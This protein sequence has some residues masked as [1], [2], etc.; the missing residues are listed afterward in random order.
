MPASV[1]PAEPEELTLFDAVLVLELPLLA[2]LLLEV[3]GFVLEEL[4]VGASEPASEE[5]LLLPHAV[6]ATLASASAAAR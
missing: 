5:L 1:E 2:E 4:L 3:P 6:A